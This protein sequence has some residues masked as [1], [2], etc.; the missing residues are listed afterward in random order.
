MP[1][2][3]PSQ[4]RGSYR[5]PGAGRLA[6]G[7]WTG[8]RGLHA[9][10]GGQRLDGGPGWP[11]CHR[12]PSP[13]PLEAEIP[14]PSLGAP[15]LLNLVW[16]RGRETQKVLRIRIC[17]WVEGSSARCPTMCPSRCPAQRQP[18]SSAPLAPSLTS[19][20]GA[21]S[22]ERAEGHR[23]RPQCLP[24]SS[25]PLVPRAKDHCQQPGCV[26]ILSCSL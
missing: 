7:R 17:S 25:P 5:A 14:P 19:S 16:A 10:S 26:P 6:W 12:C 20:D 24:G 22:R 9:P 15:P 23:V 13:W 21:P 3:R 4:R 8:P 2:P 18:G 11:G 1:W